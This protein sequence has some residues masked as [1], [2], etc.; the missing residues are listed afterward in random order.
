MVTYT[1]ITFLHICSIF[2]SL[3]RH[4]LLHCLVSFTERRKGYHPGFLLSSILLEILGSIK[5]ERF[6]SALY[7]SEGTPELDK[8]SL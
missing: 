5:M 6:L 4:N 2:H 8:G 1:D 3:L 7:L